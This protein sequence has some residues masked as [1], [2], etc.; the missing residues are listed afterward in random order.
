MVV[1]NSLQ[2]IREAMVE[3]QNEYAGRPVNHSSMYTETISSVFRKKDGRN[4]LH[5]RICNVI[6]SFFGGLGNLM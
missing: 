5:L 6:T 2:S 4:L 3:K 1:L